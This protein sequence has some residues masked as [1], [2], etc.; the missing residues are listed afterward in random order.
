[1]RNAIEAERFEAV[2]TAITQWM[3]RNGV[4]IL[5]V[6]LGVVFVWF[7]ALKLAPGMSPA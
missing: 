5:R 2:D 1:M 3:A 6:A 4:S 7:G